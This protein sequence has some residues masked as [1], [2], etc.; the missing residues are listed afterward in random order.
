MLIQSQS[1]PSNMV[2]SVPL[3]PHLSGHDLN[4]RSNQHLNLRSGRDLD[5]SS[6][7]TVLSLPKSWSPENQEDM[8]VTVYSFIRTFVG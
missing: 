8:L 1:F 6:C 2:Q 5:L 3:R 4:H 7:S